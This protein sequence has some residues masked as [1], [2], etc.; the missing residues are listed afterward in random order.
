MISFVD[1]AALGHSPLPAVIIGGIFVG[2]ALSAATR[3]T[4]HRKDP[5]RAKTRKWILSCLWLSLAVVFGLLAVFVPGP[6]HILD[7]RLGWAAGIAAAVSFLALRFRKA[8][9]LPVVV[10]L[11]ALVVVTALFLQSIRAFTGETEIASLRTI[12]VDSASMRLELVPRGGQPVLLSMKGTSFSPIVRVVIFDDLLVFLG[13][14]TWYRF[15]GMTSFDDTLRQQDSDFRFTRPDGISE[16]LWKLF[17]K[18]DAQIPGV[19][20]A[21]TEMIVKRAREFASYGIMVQNDGGVEIV[22][23]P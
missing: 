15:E 19:K 14:R 13:A 18:Y 8:A 10:L 16:S 4:R 5:E 22:Q 11:A 2:A 3:R 6:A 20:T 9:G 7:P 21:Q 12:G 17:E 1:I 23:K